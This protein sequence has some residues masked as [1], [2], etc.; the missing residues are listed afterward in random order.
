MPFPKTE[1]E[2][3]KAGYTFDHVGKCT[4]ETC[5][6]EIEWWHTPK[7]KYIPLNPGTMEPHWATCK[8]AESFRG[9]KQ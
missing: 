9:K 1:A 2:L 5:G 8:S 3:E 6:Q 7:G 4:G